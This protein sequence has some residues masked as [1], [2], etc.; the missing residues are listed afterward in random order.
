MKKF[1]K[2]LFSAALL[3]TVPVIG[4]EYHSNDLTPAGTTSGK[5]SATSGGKQ[6][7]G[8]QL[9]NTGYT[10]AVLL[11]GNALS[12]VDLHPTNYYYSMATCM[13]DSHQGGWGYSY[14]GGIHA[15][16]WNGS[17]DSYTDLNPSGYNFS[18]CLGVHNGEQAGYA[19][20]QSY[21]VTAS[22][23]MVWHGS[24]A[25]AIDL[26]PAWTTFPFSRA[27]G[28][29]NGEQVG[30]VSTVAYGEGESFGYHSSSR[31]V[32]W[33]G[34][35]ASAVDLHPA[36]FDASEATC[37]T[38]TQQGG[39]GYSVADASHVH[40]LVWSGDAASVVD[41][42]S[43]AYTETRVTAI[44]PTQQVGEG[45]IGILGSIGAVRHALVW[46]GTAESVTDL[47]QYLPSG[48]TNAV[49]TGLDSDGNIVGY[50]YNTFYAGL[51]LPPDAIAVVFAPGAAPASGLATFAIAPSNVSPGTEVQV[52]VGLSA[53]AP[54]GGLEISFLSMATNL[55]ATPA[56]VLIPEN[57]TNATFTLIAQG[58]TLT[59]PATAKIY[60]T[61]GTVSRAASLILTPRVE[62]KT[63]TA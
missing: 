29:R 47:N 1:S 11:T 25:T 16:L 24:A 27:L 10:H 51:T 63:I 50:A 19:Q 9:P 45:W 38:G 44:T 55:A 23:A 42:H 30:Y 60:V 61:D 2:H 21:F 32:R 46:A 28:C 7:G 3:M 6:A 56:P 40:A 34:T 26:H 48:Y 20:S 37:T 52:Q 43:A 57:E 18:Y 14:S 22:H 15:L 41:L 59:T 4:H 8:A 5:L 17:C 58:L 49:A 54:A 62:I 35:A 33:A 39:W 36:G 12:T 31:A 53:P 13:D